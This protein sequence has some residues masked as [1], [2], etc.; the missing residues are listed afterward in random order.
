MP[1]PLATMSYVDDVTQSPE[2][3]QP[4][5]KPAMLTPAN[6][7]FPLAAEELDGDVVVEEVAEET[8]FEVNDEGVVE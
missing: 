4:K 2:V 6:F 3:S 5:S 7:A 8:N 1:F